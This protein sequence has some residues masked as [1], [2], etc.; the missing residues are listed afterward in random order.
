MK[1]AVVLFSGGL[2]STTCLAWALKKGYKCFALSF[3]YGQRHDRENK[4]AKKIAKIM[5]VPLFNVSLFLPWLK[6]SSLVDKSKKIPENKPEKIASGKIPS[7]Y[8]PGRNLMFAS[9]GVSF[10]DAI[11]A[12]AV[13]L[14]PNAVDYSGYPDCRP[15][16]YKALNT[17]VNLGTKNPSMG[18]KIKILTPIINM[19]KAEIVKLAFK[20]N[21]P[22]KYTWSCYK[23]GKKPCGVCDSCLLRAAGFEKAGY[24]DPAL[25]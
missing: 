15:E 17:A 12:E 9:I 3:F 24:K 22:L 11:G 18:R 2:D 7:T 10:A 23:G 16:F 14:G 4:A 21:A 5:K 19:S 1:K 8:V 6:E 20:L 13:V 25:D